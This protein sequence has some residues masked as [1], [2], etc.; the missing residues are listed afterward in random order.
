[1]QTEQP[2]GC[3][4]CSIAENS[5]DEKNRVIYRGQHAFVLV[6]LY[7][8]SNGHVMVVCNRH[9][10]SFGDLADDES[11][12]LIDPA[13]GQQVRSY[14]PLPTRDLNRILRACPEAFASWSTTDLAWR[15]IG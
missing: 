5:D 15:T 8:Y 7:P 10:E 11:C 1:M 2:E 9:V 3:L 13:T 12:K 14:D 4:F 6:N